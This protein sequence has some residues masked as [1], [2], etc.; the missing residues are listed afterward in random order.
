MY[1]L[2]E[3]GE[4]IRAM[5]GAI[6]PR[7][8]L[9]NRLLSLGIDQRWRRFAVK[10]IGV[11]KTGRVLDVA[12]GTGDVA[13]EIASRTASDVSIVGVDFC[14]EMVELGRV[15]VQQAGLEER[16]ALQVAPC[17]D[18]PY[19]DET[20]EAATIAFGIRN[21]VD[22][23]KGLTEMQRVIR[24]GGRIVVLEFSKPTAP[25]FSSLYNFYFLKVLPLIGGMFSRFSAYKYLPDSVLEFPSR[26]DFK[27]IMKEAGFS[28]VKH[29]DLTGGIATVYVGVK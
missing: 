13:L 15:K 23:K 16:I 14:P 19:P 8:D 17:E 22:R 2:T 1:A 7:Y 27:G 18:I 10:Q 3:K 29:Y 28:D 26:E 20:F 6:A 11:A 25:V 24:K 12:T 21:V 9:L 5:F 4:R